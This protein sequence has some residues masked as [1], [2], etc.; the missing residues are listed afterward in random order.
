LTVVQELVL[1]RFPPLVEGR[2]IRRLNR[3]AALVDVNKREHLAHVPNSGRM[4]EL[5]VPGYR[6]LLAPAPQPSTRKTAYDLAIVDIGS[7][8]SSADARLP[9]HLVAEAIAE[10]RLPQFANYPVVRP[11]AVYGESRLDFRLEGSDGVFYVETKSV[12]LVVDGVGL[13]PDA[14]TLRGVKHLHSLMTAR[15]EGHRAGVIFVI[16]RSDAEAFAPH[17][18]ADPLLGRTLREAVAVG[19]EA[20]AYRCRLDETSIMLADS[21][22]VQ[23]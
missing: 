2:F 15:A 23:L 20:W 11:E 5:L 21:V 4:H 14:P 13:F 22:P 10:G 9:N 3:F 8:L 1:V 17:D 18:A 19:V 16:Q 6:V 12:T 7:T